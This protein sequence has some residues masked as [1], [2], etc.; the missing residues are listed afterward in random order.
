LAVEDGAVLGALF[1]KA[2]SK[3]EICDALRIYEELRQPR[4]TKVVRESTAYRD[5]THMDD[6]DEQQERDRQMT[7]CK[8]FE[9]YPNRWADSAFQEYLFGY[10][11][12][13]VAAEAWSKYKA[14]MEQV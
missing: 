9:G 8:P 13:S 6:G 7:E 3:P 14:G 12:Y 4:T 10:D 5:I 2:E 1:E 11:A